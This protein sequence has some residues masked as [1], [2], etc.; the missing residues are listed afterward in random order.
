MNKPEL[1]SPAGDP[2][3]LRIAVAYGADAVYLSGKAFGLRAQS[4][5]FSNVELIDSVA[6]A[7]EHRVQCYATMNIYAHPDDFITMGEQLDAYVDAGIDACIV[8]DPGVFSF[9][10]QRVPEMP[11][12]ISTQASVTNAET[13][14]F[15]YRL[16]VR[17]VVLAR[18]LTLEE[19]KNI[20]ASVPDDMELECFIHGAMC[21]SYSGRCLLSDFYTGRSGNKGA[22]AQPC[23]WE[24]KVTEVKRPDQVLTVEGDERGSYIFSSNDLC[25]IDHVP[26][27]IEAGIN[28]FKI[29]GR[30]KGAFYVASA[31][32]AYRLA[33]DRYFKDPDAYEVDSQWREWIGRTVH[34]EFATG[35]FFDQPKDNPRIFSD[36]TYHKPA[37]VVGVVIGY[38]ADHGRVIVE[39]KNKVNEG[40]TV[41][42]MTPNGFSRDIIL[43]DLR[44]ADGVS[45]ASTPHARMFYSFSSDIFIETYSF[46]SKV[47]NKDE[48]IA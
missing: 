18:E 42:L 41:T 26:Q 14:M 9:I 2:E 32:K 21:V 34:R 47:G 33:I 28:S 12:H 36:K 22:C 20:R 30:I 29:E 31:T 1:L 16:G 13:C 19:I 24:Y 5:N 27:L 3:K 37:Y 40:D 11:I 48:G 43:K 15:W 17:R 23:R 8:S 38:D 39:Q 10:R 7:H 46:I 35:F 4:T 45:I 25:M 44:D 6:Y